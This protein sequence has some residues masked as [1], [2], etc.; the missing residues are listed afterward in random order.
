MVLVRRSSDSETRMLMQLV[1]GHQLL[2]G[3]CFEGSSLSFTARKTVGH[4]GGGQEPGLAQDKV[5]MLLS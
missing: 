5:K 1:G 2:D 3:L 4:Y